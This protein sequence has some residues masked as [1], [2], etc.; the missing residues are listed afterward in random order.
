MN[1]LAIL[2]LPLA[3][4][5][6]GLG[7]PLGKLAMRELDPAHMVLLRFIVASI[8]ACPFPLATK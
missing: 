6:W 4:L 7:F 3:G 1:P 2:A 5:A 8:V